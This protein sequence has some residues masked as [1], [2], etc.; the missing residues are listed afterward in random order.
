MTCEAAG[1]DD[2]ESLERQPPVSR[3]WVEYLVKDLNHSDHGPSVFA[4]LAA[5]LCKR[6]ICDNFLPATQP[7]WGG[8]YGQDARSHPVL[9]DSHG[10]WPLYQSAP[11]VS[12]RCIFAFSIAADWKSKLRADAEKTVANGFDP[13]QI[14]FLTNQFIA[15]ESRK[16]KAEREVSGAIS[17]GKVRIQ[18]TIFDGSWFVQQLYGQDYDL[19]VEYLEC[20]AEDDPR[21]PEILGR[22]HG[23]ESAGMSTEEAAHVERLKQQLRF[24]VDYAGTPQLL[25]AD[26]RRVADVLSDYEDHIEEGLRLYEEGI[27]VPTSGLTAAEKARCY[28]GYFRACMKLPH[29]PQTIA[30]RFPEFTDLLLDNEFTSLFYQIPARLMYLA[31]WMAESP[32][33]ARLLEES[34]RKVREYSKERLGSLSLA[35]LDEALLHFTLLDCGKSGRLQPWVESLAGFVDRVADLRPFPIGRL[36]AQLSRAA[37]AFHHLEGFEKAYQRALDAQGARTS[38]ADTAQHLKDRSVAHAQNRQF[39]RAIG[40]AQRAKMLWFGEDTSR[41]F[42]L[43]CASLSIWYAEL[44]LL[45]AAEYELLELLAVSTWQPA[46]L[47]PDLITTALFQL[48]TLA[49]QQ[50]RF[51]RAFG[52]LLLH[53]RASALHG[54]DLE[55]D[56]VERYL[57]QNGVLLLGH[58]YRRHRALHD[59]LMALLEGVESSA[60]DAYRSMVA[61]GDAE[62]HAWCRE[63]PPAEREDAERIR[64]R[65]HSG[66]LELSNVPMDYDELAPVQHIDCSL[67][68]FFRK[69][70]DRIRIAHA[71]GSFLCPVAFALAA[72]LQEWV[73]HVERDF[74]SMVFTGEPVEIRLG[75]AC[76][77]PADGIW[78]DNDLEDSMF[79][80]RVGVSEDF[81]RSELSGRST[82][83]LVR[84]FLEVVGQLVCWITLDDPD[85]V[86]ELF[87]PSTAGRVIH[88][89]LLSGPPI[90]AWLSPLAHAVLGEEDGTA[91]VEP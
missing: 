27:G 52:W 44:G 58:T 70:L 87:R 63:L 66:E 49:V 26:L 29:G 65:V 88:D 37:P 4:D 77:G 12:E 82:A 83:G 28:E 19:A 18:V 35:Y 68:P 85:E 56:V 31:P 81:Y 72:L 45:Q 80:V 38:A 14:I 25:V 60:I 73:V 55:E 30:E 20:P 17:G 21:G 34:A 61:T 46:Y 15:P 75:E 54:I 10:Q 53:L 91:Q 86:L 74:D 22:V 9:L 67:E 1:T 13:D 36:C 51:L 3:K 76:E 90:H 48:H 40:C 89:A 33:Y 43:L 69:P 5:G 79:V 2:Q 41:G 6:R 59:R 24:R 47:H 8:D 84:L 64:R 50:G 57:E 42:L 78:V 23:L 7:S 32:E 39:V 11:T 71:R 62:F 16:I